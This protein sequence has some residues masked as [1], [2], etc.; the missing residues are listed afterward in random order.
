MPS[1]PK[2]TGAKPEL[3]FLDASVLLYAAGRPHPL[4]EPCRAALR[5]ALER[6][7]ALITDAEVLQEIL[8]R[9]TSIDR[10]DAARTVYRSAVDLCDEV[11]SVGEAH[12]ARALELLLEHPELSA[13][14]ALHAAT[15]EDRGIVRILSTDRDFDALIHLRRLEPADL[16]G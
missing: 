3:C 8:H 7:I 4:R 16:A 12:T 1:R 14:D 2:P 15:M 11:L 9:Y 5:A 13:R 10:L 6:G